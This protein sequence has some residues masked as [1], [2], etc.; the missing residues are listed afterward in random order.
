LLEGKERFSKKELSILFAGSASQKNY[1]SHLA[2]GDFTSER[3]LGRKTLLNIIRFGKKHSEAALSVLETDASWLVATGKRSGF[4]IPTWI[5]GR[6]ELNDS[7]EE[8]LRTGNVKEDLRR[9]RKNK[10]QF[11][12]R[13]DQKI[14]FDF[15]H[16]MYVP[17][18]KKVHGDRAILHSYTDLLKKFEKSELLLI[19]MGNEFV[20]GQIL[21]YENGKVRTR[22]LGIKDA[23]FR[24]VK[25][26]AA[27]ALYYFGLT[28]LK[29]RGFQYVNLGGSRAFLN[30]GVLQF[31]KKWG[32]Q[33]ILHQPNIFI[34]QPLQ[35]TAGV[36][37]FLH[38]NPI[39]Y[40]KDGE[41]NGAIFLSDY[42]RITGKT[43]KNFQKKYSFNGLKELNYFTL[44]DEPQGV[45]I[46]KKNVEIAKFI[47]D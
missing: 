26:G 45:A 23:D 12:V 47:I 35:A 44:K 3:A 2:F 30:D 28:Y 24:F 41:L 21:I 20:S 15:Y 46:I 39:I 8:T 17:Y 29:D 33:L 37:G 36:R 9:I 4:C 7:F 22:E 38:N 25:A 11:V 14:F 6:V 1:I 32:I 18:V 34:L 16:D 31:K 27:A 13:R 42:S 5:N 19:K 40:Q 10:L 43:F